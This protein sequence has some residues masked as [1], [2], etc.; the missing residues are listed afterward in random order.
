M[1]VYYV[2]HRIQYADRMSRKGIGIFRARRDAEAAIV[3]VRDKEGFRDRRG[4]FLVYAIEVGR[5]YGANG[6]ES[7]PK[8]T[9]SGSLAEAVATNVPDA[10]F[11]AYLDNAETDDDFVIF[12]YFETEAE[13]R[14]VIDEISTASPIEPPWEYDVGYAPVDQIGWSEGFVVG[15]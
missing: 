1:Q 14:A 11:S 3:Q 10:L 13:A 12:G 15:D 7:A 4:I 2:Q 8:S 9:A 6:V 5:K